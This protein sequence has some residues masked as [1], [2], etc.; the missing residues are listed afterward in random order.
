MS[1][2]GSQVPLSSAEVTWLRDEIDPLIEAG[3][4]NAEPASAFGLCECGDSRAL[5]D[6]KSLAHL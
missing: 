6:F 1:N 4:L 2:R 3:H 5:S